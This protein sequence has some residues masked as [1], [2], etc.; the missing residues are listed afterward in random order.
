LGKEEQT[1]SEMGKEE[2]Q[3]EV[4]MGYHT[5]EIPKGELGEISKIREE[6]AEFEDGVKQDCKLLILCELADLIGAIEAY[7]LK[8]HNVELEDLIQMMNLTKS[9]FIEGKRVNVADSR[10][11]DA[12]ADLMSKL[13]MPPP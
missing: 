8:H 3:I 1:I 2:T 5:T 11:R 6:I 4:I 7:T 13:D 10:L 9:A 12:Y